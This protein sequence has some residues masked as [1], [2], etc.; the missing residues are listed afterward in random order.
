[1]GSPNTAVY[2]LHGVKLIHDELAH[3]GRCGG[4]AHVPPVRADSRLAGADA[5]G[6]EGRSVNDRG[7]ERTLA[8]YYGA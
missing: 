3:T 4:A 8:D 5:G 1:M 2:H 7:R 6:D